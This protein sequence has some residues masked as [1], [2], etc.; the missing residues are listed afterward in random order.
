MKY[1]LILALGLLTVACTSE[2]KEDIKDLNDILPDSERDYDQ[3]D[4][5]LVDDADTLGIYQ[6]RFAELGE[7]DS[8]NV[9]EEDLFPDRFGPERIEKF[10]LNLAGEEVVFVKWRFQDSARV[11]NALFNWLDCFGENCKSIRVSEERNLLKNA[12]HIFANDTVLVYVESKKRIDAKSWDKYFEE[13]GYELDWDVLMEQ[14]PRG[15][16]QWFTYLDE[17]KIPVK[18]ELL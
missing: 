7:L 4:S 14:A 16:V 2:T 8:I 5:V 9:C 17:E 13:N 15:R 3:K 6:A 12:F 10:R 18:N 11:T 1:L